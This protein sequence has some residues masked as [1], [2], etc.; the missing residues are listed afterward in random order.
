MQA[1]HQQRAA[2]A[3][4]KTQCL[5]LCPLTQHLPAWPSALSVLFREPGF[6]DQ[7]RKPG[8]ERLP[9][10]REHR[11]PR[12]REH[13]QPAALSDRWLPTKFLFPWVPYAS[14]LVPCP[15]GSFCRQILMQS[16]CVSY[17]LPHSF[18]EPC[19]RPLGV[20]EQAG[21]THLPCDLTLALAHCG[22][23]LLHL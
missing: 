21:T 8:S 14:R 12:R 17:S 23:C 13:K 3:W 6:R 11:L 16:S 10:R 22:L 19:R 4:E 1:L 5:S 9:S 18:L 7:S 15:S 2:P 20:Q